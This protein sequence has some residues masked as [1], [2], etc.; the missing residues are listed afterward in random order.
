MIF[1]N[2]VPSLCCA[3]VPSHPDSLLVTQSSSTTARATWLLTNSTA[4][5]GAH[6]LKLTLTYAHNRSHA[7]TITLPGGTTSHLLE[8]LAPATN[9]TL[10]ATAINPDGMASS[11]TQFF[12]TREG[13]ALLNSVTVSHINTTHIAIVAEVA[14]TGGGAIQTFRVTYGP[15]LMVDLQ[16]VEPVDPLRYRGL[17][18]REPSDEPQVLTVSVINQHNYLSNTRQVT[19]KG[20]Q[21]LQ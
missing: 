19:G 15:G 12:A 3:V 11:H 9:Y 7:D 5:S 13:R 8:G 2:C 20:I 16:G 17:L 1:T 4:D 14:Y 10:Q 6:T 18:E 21:R